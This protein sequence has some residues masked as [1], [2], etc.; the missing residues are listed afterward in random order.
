MKLSDLKVVHVI[1]VIVTLLWIYLFIDWQIT[2]YQLNFAMWQKDMIG[3]VNNLNERLRGAEG[4][5]GIPSPPP[6][7]PPSTPAPKKGP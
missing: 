2:K 5:R 7:I 3:A 6:Q 4:V 1:L